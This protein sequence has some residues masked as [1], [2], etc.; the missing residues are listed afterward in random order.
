MSYRQPAR[1]IPELNDVA[2]PVRMNIQNGATADFAIPCWYIDDENMINDY[3][4]H[5]HCD[6]LVDMDK[7]IP[8]H[9]R[10]EGYTKASI[11][12]IDKPA[13][14]TATASIDNTYDHIIR[15]SLNAQVP[16]ATTEAVN[17]TFVVHVVRPNTIDIVYHGVLVILPTP[18][19]EGII[20]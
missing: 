20:A 8:I 19:P 3:P 10:E 6:E 1:T 14:L 5:C 16:T 17:C 7:L 13:G 18:L 4:Y 15:I 2:T 11:S 9:L 12:F